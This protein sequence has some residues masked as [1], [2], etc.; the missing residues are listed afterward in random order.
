MN[1]KRWRTIA[2][3]GLGSSDIAAFGS[4]TEVVYYYMH[5]P[6]F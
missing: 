1:H 6:L 5:F 2:V 4:T 3:I